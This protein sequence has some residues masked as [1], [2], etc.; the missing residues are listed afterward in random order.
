[1]PSS[2]VGEIHHDVRAS[3]EFGHVGDF[4][5]DIPGAGAASGEDFGGKSLAGE[6]ITNLDGCLKRGA[7]D[8]FARLRDRRRAI[9]LTE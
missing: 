3:L 5:I 4:E 7:R 8:L 1:M 6:E 9:Q 2:P